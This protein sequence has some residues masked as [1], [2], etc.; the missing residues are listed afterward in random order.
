[1]SMVQRLSSIVL[2]VVASGA[3]AAGCLNAKLA[4]EPAGDETTA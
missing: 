2:V 4:P 1:M 3:V